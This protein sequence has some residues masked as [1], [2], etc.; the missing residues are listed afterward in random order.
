MNVMQSRAP[1]CCC[2]NYTFYPLGWLFKGACL[3]S[4]G[5]TRLSAL[6]AQPTT[7]LGLSHPCTRNTTPDRIKN[8]ARAPHRPFVPLSS[9]SPKANYPTDLT[10]AFVG[11]VLCCAL[12]DVWALGKLCS[13]GAY[14]ARLEEEWRLAP[15]EPSAPPAVTDP[16]QDLWVRTLLVGL[17]NGVRKQGAIMIIRLA[18]MIV[19]PCLMKVPA[20]Q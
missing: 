17:G 1:R 18:V 3:H 2:H 20:V 8:N 19:T 14:A 9:Y 6:T 12:S 10:C 4:T 16:L 15:H 7:Q 13:L 11:A 5:I